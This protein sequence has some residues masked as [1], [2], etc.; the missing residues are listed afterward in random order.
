MNFPTFLRQLLGG[1]LHAGDGPVHRRFR[2]RSKYLKRKVVVDCYRPAL[3]PTRPLR[4]LVCN[5]GQ[6]FARLD[7]ERHFSEYIRRFPQQPILVVGL[8]AADRLREYGTAGQ[9]DHANRGDL[10]F[11]HEQFV[12]LELLP[13]LER[14]FNLRP[15]AEYR[16]YAGFSLGGLAAFDLV[17]RHPDIFQTAGVFSGALWWRAKP[18]DPEYPDADRIVH[19]YVRAA[20]RVD[21]NFRCWLMAGTEDETSDRNN[22]GIIDAIDD[23]LQLKALL[24]VKG[25]RGPSRLTYV[26]VEG[27]R[28]E[29]ATWGAVFPRFLSWWVSG[30]G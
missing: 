22:N 14:R 10:A 7:F 1:M 19:E 25:M 13:K 9:P 24:E 16:A 18:F 23:T 2:I 12:L 29:P 11:A 21:P 17:W 20:E 26:E 28:H 3:P 4:L 8:E 30:R 15:E 27:G 6:D 5:D